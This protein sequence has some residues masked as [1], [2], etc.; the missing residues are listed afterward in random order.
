MP[1]VLA[2][3][4][5]V[6]ALGIQQRARLVRVLGKRGLAL[7][8][9]GAALAL[10][11]VPATRQ[12]LLDTLSGTFALVVDSSAL[13]VDPTAAVLERRPSGAAVYAGVL[14]KAVLQNC[15]TS[16][17]ALRGCSWPSETL[18]RGAP[19]GLLAGTPLAYFLFYGVSAWH[20]GLCYNMRYLL[21]ALPFAAMASVLG[22][23]VLVAE[24]RAWLPC[25]VGG[26][27][28]LT[29][30]LVVS[31]LKPTR[32]QRSSSCCWYPC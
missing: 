1:W 20:G 10:V 26:A 16:R 4:V 3:L 6:A 31:T 14:K 23:R 11:V 30:T 19:R 18:R 5:G 28:A 12:I 29:L 21:P 32:K 24:R 7:G 13:P 25:L 15:R 17:W 9:A 22:L 8:L 2:A 27:A